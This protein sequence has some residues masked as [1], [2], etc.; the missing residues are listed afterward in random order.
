MVQCKTSEFSKYYKTY[1]RSD[2]LEANGM[3]ELFFCKY[4]VLLAIISTNVEAARHSHSCLTSSHFPG[5]REIAS[6]YN[7]CW[8]W[9]GLECFGLFITSLDLLSSIFILSLLWIF[10]LMTPQKFGKQPMFYI[11]Q[12]FLFNFTCFFLQNSQKLC[13]F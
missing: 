8:R 11:I 3:M 9:V 1:I 6:M 12:T 13:S 2:Q 7:Q 4:H 5:P 10:I